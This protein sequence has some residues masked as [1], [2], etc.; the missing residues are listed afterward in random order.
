MK[1]SALK[2]LRIFATLCGQKAMPHVTIVTTKWT[3]VPV[4]RG[5]RREQELK[6]SFW[7][8]MIADGCET[9]RFKDTYESAWGIIG[10]LGDRRRPHVLLPHEIVDS[11]LQLPKTRAGITLHRELEELI[12]IQKESADRLR[13][14]AQNQD[15]ELVIQ[16]LNNQRAEIEVKIRNTEDQLHK[17][18]N[19]FAM[20]IRKFFKGR[21]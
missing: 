2:N 3:E 14:L 12:K 6:T 19:P 18:K 9:A 15:N 10:S 4:E 1:G 16:E 11:E 20:R 21:G 17:M 13:R 7:K 8:E 5:V